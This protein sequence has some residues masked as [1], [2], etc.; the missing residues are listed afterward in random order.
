VTR[1]IR[2]SALVGHSAE[3]IFDLIDAAERYPEFLPWC[4]A[5]TVLARDEQVV[6]ARLSINYH[7][8]RLN[9][10]TRND[11]RRPEFMSIRLAEGPFKRFEGEWHLVALAPGACKIDFALR[12][13][14]ENTL[15]RLA[16]PVFDRIAET[17]V[18]A[19]VARAEQVYGSPP[20]TTP[21]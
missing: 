6:S 19:F 20:S 13:E 7:G 12:Y 3:R 15:A 16:S 5:A 18:D 1:E 8:V 2:K 10:A 14:L 17:L 4:A 9:F 11:K 21:G